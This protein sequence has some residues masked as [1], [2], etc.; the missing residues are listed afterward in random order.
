MRFYESEVRTTKS[1]SMIIDRLI[2]AYK[3][4]YGYEPVFRKTK[5]GQ[6]FIYKSDE[7]AKQ[8]HF[9]TALGNVYAVEAWLGGVVMAKAGQLN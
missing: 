7:D 5:G 9:V 2:E 4:Q 8:N 1:E 6:F 3:T